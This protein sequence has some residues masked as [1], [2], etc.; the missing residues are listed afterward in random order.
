MSD[1]PVPITT[2]GWSPIAIF[3]FAADYA[4]EPFLVWLPD[5]S[6]SDAWVHEDGAFID[7]TWRHV[8]SEDG[9]PLTEVSEQEPV[10]YKLVEGPD[11]ND[12]AHIV[13]HHGLAA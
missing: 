1:I 9:S 2:N 11:L 5:G 8:C 12:L 13:A 6:W 7:G 4:K 3:D 10:A